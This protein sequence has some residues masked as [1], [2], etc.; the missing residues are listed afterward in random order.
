MK[1][2]LQTHPWARRTGLSSPLSLGSQQMVFASSSQE[3]IMGSHLC[4]P[5]EQKEIC[6]ALVSLGLVCMPALQELVNNPCHPGIHSNGSSSS[7]D[8]WARELSPDYSDIQHLSR[9]SGKCL[10]HQV[11]L[12]V[13]GVESGTLCMHSRLFHLSATTPSRV[14]FPHQHLLTD[15]FF[16]VQFTKGLVYKLD[17]CIFIIEHTYGYVT[18]NR[19]KTRFDIGCL[20]KKE[21]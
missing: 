13:S 5:C 14:H 11:Q 6:A 17:L 16:P 8:H 19:G 20:L 4:S 9:A 1:A 15:R 3:L 12:E 10:S 7:S 2:P 21:W 18:C